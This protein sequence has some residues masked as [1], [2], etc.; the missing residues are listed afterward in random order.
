MK[1]HPR[2][3]KKHNA[4]E[5]V[6]QQGDQDIVLL[7]RDDTCK[8]VVELVEHANRSLLLHTENLDAAVFDQR[9]FLD[10]VTRLL[11]NNREARLLILIQDGRKAIQDNN[12]LIELSRRM[13]TQIQFRRPASQHRDN[14][15]TFLLADKTAYLLCPLPGRY[16]GNVSLANPG[17]VKEL[18]KYFTE[19]WDHAEPDL[20]M[21]RLHL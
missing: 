11:L 17:K 18:S 8:A 13:S 1:E 15:K 7:S 16:E 14:H 4:A 6:D 19:V 21:R 9:P 20:E 2:N 12:R 5:P 10:A 3:K